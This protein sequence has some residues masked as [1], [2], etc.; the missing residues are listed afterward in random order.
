MDIIKVLCYGVRDV[1]KPFFEDLNKKYNYEIT[2]VKEYLN[3]KET[4]ELAKGHEAVILRGNCWANK[5]NLD[6]YKSL[7]VKY[8]LTRTVGVNHIDV[9]Y[10]KELGMKLAYVPGYSPNAIA[11]LAVTHAMMLARHMAYTADKAA[12]QHDFKVDDFMF[13]KEIRNCTV[14]II[15]LGRI[16]RVTAQIFRGFGAT[17]I[18]QDLFPAQNLPEGVTQVEMDELLKRSD[19]ISLHCPYIAENGKVVTKE[20]ISKMKKGAILVNAARGELQDIDA[21]IEAIENGQLGGCGLDTLDGESEIFFKSFEG[22]PVPNEKLNKLISLYPKVLI[23]PHI[24]SYTD[25]AVSNMVEY[26]YENLKEY[27]ETGDCKNKIK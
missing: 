2:C 15:G 4:A 10:A 23:S 25:E 7:G 18:G 17:V 9:P 6:I 13:S 3:T 11:E 24:G 26:T 20:F 21:T 16:G 14:G 22:K 1:E 19:I 8:V 12:Y 5:E 27:I